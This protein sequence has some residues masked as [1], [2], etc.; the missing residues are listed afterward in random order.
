ML[1]I[2]N[3]CVIYEGAM[4]YGYCA[5][6]DNNAY[7]DDNAYQNDNANQDYT[8]KQDYWQLLKMYLVAF[9]LLTRSVFA[10][11]SSAKYGDEIRYFFTLT[12]ARERVS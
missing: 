7:Q 1:F 11:V 3:I 8:R 12:R 4:L 10:V 2:H 5:Y 9:N 6:Q